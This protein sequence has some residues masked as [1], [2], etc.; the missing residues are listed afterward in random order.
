MTVTKKEDTGS[1][2]KTNSTEK[3]KRDTTT[4]LPKDGQQ[5][6]EQ[7]QEQ[8][9]NNEEPVLKKAKVMMVA[10]KTPTKAPQQKQQKQQQQASLLQFFS[11][12][13]TKKKE[14]KSDLVT[15]RNDTTDDSAV[16]KVALTKLDMTVTNN[17]NLAIVPTPTIPTPSTVQWKSLHDQH[18]LVRI[19]RLDGNPL[20]TKVAAFDL[21]G[22]LVRWSN[23]SPGFWPSRLDHY[24]L[25]NHSVITKLQHLYDQQGYLLVVFTNQGGIQK[26]HGGKRAT[27]VKN[28]LDWIERLV[29]RPISAIASTRSMKKSP[30]TSFHKPKPDMWNKIWVGSKT[31]FLEQQGSERNRIV[32]EY[33]DLQSSFFVGDSADPNDS[34]GGVDRQ[35]ASNVGIAFFTPEE[36]FGPSNQQL[37]HQTTT[38]TTNTTMSFDETAITIPQEALY[39]RKALLGG[40]LK[41]PIMLILV[42]VQGSGKSYFCRQITT[43]QPQEHEHHQTTTTTTTTKTTIPIHHSPQWIWL[44]QDTINNGKPGKREKVQDEAR[45]S[46]QNGKSVI[47]DRM[48]LDPEQRNYFVTVAND[49]H[50]PTHIVVLNPLRDVVSERVKIRTNHPGKVQ[51]ENGSK[52]ALA[53]MSRLVMPNYNEGVALINCATSE[54]SANFLAMRYRI[55]SICSSGPVTRISKTIPLP[56]ATITTST[57]TTLIPT[58]TLGTMGIGKRRCQEIVSTMLEAGFDAIDT[59]PTYQNEQCVGQAL[60]KE[61]KNI[62]IIAKIQ[63]RAVTAN[64]VLDELKKTLAN[65]QREFVDLLLLHW[66]SDVIAGNT[67]I[68]VWTAMEQ[69]VQDGKCK[70][71]GVCNFNQAALI[72]LL[73]ICNIPPIINQIE[74]HPFLAQMDVV[75]FCARNNIQVQAHTPLGQGSEQLLAD[76]TI[77]IVS[78]ETSL[79]PAQIVLLWNIQQ[80][81]PVVPKCTQKTHVN[82]ILSLVKNNNRA[83]S[84]NNIVVL[85]P[86]HM[87]AIDRLDNGTRLVAPPFMYGTG[88][89]SWGERLPLRNNSRK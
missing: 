34:Q 50:V 57:S 81:I 67:L 27:L 21:D 88:I 58:L 3:E 77:Q 72:Q 45:K 85:S 39:A 59:A 33:Y 52:L 49:C 66:P 13:T 68:Q 71:L 86:Q 19:P 38:T 26:A 8:A 11:S 2:N 40:Y 51:G 10:T 44:S 73:K 32:P 47:I 5:Q 15:V 7:E 80:G 6:R 83:E 60:I 61:P 48:N 43:G 17:N 63:K 1:L 76:E 87:K 18:V 46:L 53:S 41:G 30:E 25:W 42:G 82:E 23:E 55:M 37:R 74:R 14:A 65:L 70:A 64:E 75:D 69:C 28:I 35:F 4:V 62:Y 29:Q 84:T 22:T 16:A 9:P 89:Y 56:S 24:E 12:S 54:Y 20:R 36:Y 31:L 79:T 78:K